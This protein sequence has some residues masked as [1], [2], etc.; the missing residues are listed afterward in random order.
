MRGATTFQ[1]QAKSVLEYFWKD[2]NPWRHVE[3]AQ[4][5]DNI[6]RLRMIPDSLL[7]ISCMLE[8]IV[9]LMVPM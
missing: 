8:G 5:D 7:C 1:P 3:I 9:A 6:T 4:N 2:V